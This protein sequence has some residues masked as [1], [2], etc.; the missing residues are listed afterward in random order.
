MVARDVNPGYGKSQQ[1]ISPP[2]EFHCYGMPSPARGGAR[3]GGIILF[4]FFVMASLPPPPPGLSANWRRRGMCPTKCLL[5]AATGKYNVAPA[6]TG[7]LLI[8]NA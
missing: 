1:K 8:L 7:D 5:S 2:L 6:M 3:G 4:I